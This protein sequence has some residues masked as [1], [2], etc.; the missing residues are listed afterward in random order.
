VTA[1]GWKVRRPRRA[2]LA[3]RAAQECRR[4]IREFR[5]IRPF[6]LVLA[7]VGCVAPVTALAACVKTT[8][9]LSAAGFHQLIQD[10]G[11]FRYYRTVTLADGTK[12]KRWVPYQ[13]SKGYCTV[14][15]GHL[16]P[17]AGPCTPARVKQWTLTNTQ[18]DALLQKDV[19]SRVAKVNRL[20]T[21]G[22]TQAQFDALVNF[23][24]NAGAGKS[25]YRDKRG[26]LHKPGL[27]GSGILAAVNAGDDRLAGQR[28]LSYISRQERLTSKGL[29]SRRD[30]EATPFLSTESVPC[31][32]ATKPP[33]PTPPTTPPTSPPTTPPTAPPSSVRVQVDMYRMVFNNGS[34]QGAGTV[35]SNPAGI[36]C[37]V[38][39]DF[40]ASG[41]AV[42]G[43]CQASFAV[44]T[45]LTL[46]ATTDPQSSVFQGWS[47]AAG[48]QA[49]PGDPCFV[50]GTGPCTL[51]LGTSGYEIGASFGLQTRVLT[52]DN[53]DQSH[54]EILVSAPVGG[55]QAICGV[56]DER[57][58]VMYPFGQPVIADAN[59][60]NPPITGYSL[61]GCDAS[62]PGTQPCQVTMTAAKT[63]TVTWIEQ[64]G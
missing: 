27:I 23:V 12:A 55:Q 62:Y 58:S 9:N 33:P 63:L 19:Q 38:S 1:G 22:L 30:R 40:S 11:G 37:S 45:H 14:G 56:E 16:I 8:L 50:Q 39:R 24:Y 17:P 53:A 21:R 36:S 52:I 28:I 57:C 31:P 26:R 60:Q 5:R 35:T 6:I 18:A 10:E 2:V 7:A 59:G 48:R 4:R 49:T 54:G 44:G 41:P 29:I 43:T 51:T 46:T 61:Q 13:D 15:H 3:R 20:V 34:V 25:A 42:S 32:P 47:D 64:G